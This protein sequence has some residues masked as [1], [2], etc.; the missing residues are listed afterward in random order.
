MHDI[1]Q[2]VH[3]WTHAQVGKWGRPTPLTERAG[4]ALRTQWGARNSLARASQNVR[5]S[6]TRYSETH[7][8]KE[9]A[10]LGTRGQSMHA[11]IGA[12]G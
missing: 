7:R 4:L 5:G 11:Q 12:K 8:N 9:H 2:R 1:N 6:L 10:P 3:Q